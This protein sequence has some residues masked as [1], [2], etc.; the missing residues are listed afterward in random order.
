MLF[1]LLS[2]LKFITVIN[3]VYNN[4]LIQRNLFQ[5][6]CTTNTRKEGQNTMNIENGRKELG[7]MKYIFP[8][9]LYLQ[10]D[11]YCK[12]KWFTLQDF[13][14]PVFTPLTL[15]STGVQ[16]YAVWEGDT[17]L[18]PRFW[19]FIYRWPISSSQSL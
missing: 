18:Y 14:A 4:L 1:I 15:K 13:V 3:C 17:Q 12:R 9:L 5:T 6:L 16:E 19:E 2:I 10:S 11:Y 8:L 7:R